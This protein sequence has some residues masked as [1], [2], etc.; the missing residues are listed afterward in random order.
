MPDIAPNPTRR[1][2][3]VTRDSEEALQFFT[4]HFGALPLRHLAISPIPGGFGQGF[5]G[6]VYAST[7]SYY[8]ADDKPLQGLNSGARLFY[9]EQL[10]AHEIAHQWW[11]NTLTELD[12]HDL[13]LIES[14]ADYSAL[15]FLERHK[16]PEALAGI[17]ARYKANLLLKTESGET[18]ESAGAIVLGD[19]L[20]TSR[21]P[22]ARETITYEK[23]TWVLHMLRRIM[24]DQKFFA[25]LS[26]LRKKYEYK[27]VST[28]QF[29]E[30]AAQ[31]LPP[32]FSDP[33]LENFFSHW[34]YSTGIPTL[35]MQ[36]KV[37]GKEP[38]L[39]L[40]GVIRQSGVPE[41]FSVGV[42]VS[43]QTAAGGPK[44]ETRVQT[45]N[46]ET[47]FSVSL[48]QRPSRVIL[49]PRDSVLAIKQ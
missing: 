4:E 43:V 33:G 37:T 41:D 22:R 20:R 21:T 42:A 17:L 49:D 25:M 14:L 5:P 12:Y 35:E 23:G 16:G 7:L 1:L 39:K 34:V 32:N 40:N 29:R 10:R 31:F 24:G 38:A 45:A 6:L 27:T 8:E 47:P 18:V 36:Y 44:T 11:G 13:W 30:L 2:D 9:S 15:L 3:E 48:K 46:G 26:E 19:R 28:E